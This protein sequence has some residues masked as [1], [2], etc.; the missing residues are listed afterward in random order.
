MADCLRDK[1]PGSLVKHVGK[2]KDRGIDIYCIIDEEPCLVQ[3]KR[4]RD[5]RIPEGPQAIRELN[6]VLLRE[7]VYKGIFI[8]TAK[9]FTEAAVGELTIKMETKKPVVI[10]LISFDGII[11]MVSK[12]TENYAPWENYIVKG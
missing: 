2:S 9:R 3:V 8:S 1:F 7:G 10:E 12:E 4:R 11:D 6:G 5:G